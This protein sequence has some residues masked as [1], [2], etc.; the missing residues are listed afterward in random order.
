MEECKGFDS[1][2]KGRPFSFNIHS[3]YLFFIDVFYANKKLFGNMKKEA[4]IWPPNKAITNHFIQA[5]L[6]FCNRFCY[7]AF[8]N[9]GL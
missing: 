5:Y 1:E 2:S 4:M 3:Q 9:P 8:I 7:D 6:F